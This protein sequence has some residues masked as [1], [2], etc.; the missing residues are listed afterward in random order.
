M[1]SVVNEIVGVERSL[2]LHRG[3]LQ[4]HGEA[5]AGGGLGVESAPFAG[6]EAVFA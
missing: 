6:L 1:S 4:L 5:E 3:E 2:G